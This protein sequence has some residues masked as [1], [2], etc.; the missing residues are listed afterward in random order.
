MTESKNK[1]RRARIKSVD[2]K[3]NPKTVQYILFQKLVRAKGQDNTYDYKN[4][5]HRFKTTH[6][7]DQTLQQNYLINIQ[8]HI[9]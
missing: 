3:S 8:E 5:K 9:I 2:Q 1:K 7:Y 6:T 4:R